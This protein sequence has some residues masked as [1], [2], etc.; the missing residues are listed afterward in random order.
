VS[1]TFSIGY[2]FL[3][4][5]WRRRCLFSA[6]G[7]VVADILN[8][9]RPKTGHVRLLAV[10]LHGCRRIRYGIDDR[11]GRQVQLG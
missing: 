4:F 7:Q 10:V 5:G 1:G 8:A 6:I 9:V 2:T 3:H 11:S